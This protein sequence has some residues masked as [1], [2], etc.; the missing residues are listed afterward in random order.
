[1][2]SKGKLITTPPEKQHWVDKNGV[3]HWEDLTKCP[4]CKEEVQWLLDMEKDYMWSHEAGKCGYERDCPH[5][6][7][8]IWVHSSESDVRDELTLSYIQLGKE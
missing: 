4:K 3:E 2:R 8:E 5:C 6:G 7:V 1:M